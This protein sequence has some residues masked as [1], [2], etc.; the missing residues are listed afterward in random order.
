M[1]RELECAALTLLVAC[2]GPQV[3]PM[4]D[5]RSGVLEGKRVLLVPLAVSDPLG[6]ER[7]GI[8]L[9]DA[10]RLRASAAA[11]QRIAQDQD[12]TK[13]VCGETGKSQAIAELELL[14]ARDQQIPARLWMRIRNEY[15]RSTH[16]SFVQRAWHL[17]SRWDASETFV[18]LRRR[19]PWQRRSS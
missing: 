16:C 14:F 13:I 1:S 11:C 7:T 12:D 8:V 9:S 4:A 17:R 10:A 6:D 2:G 3:R 5:Y 19:N 18:G 15:V